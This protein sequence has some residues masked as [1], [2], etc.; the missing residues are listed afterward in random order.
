MIPRVEALFPKETF[1]GFSDTFQKNEGSFEHN[2]ARVNLDDVALISLSIA[3]YIQNHT[4][5]YEGSQ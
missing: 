3:S 2:P 5:S 1:G 4:M